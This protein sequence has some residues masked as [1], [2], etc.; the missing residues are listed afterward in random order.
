M[1]RSCAGLSCPGIHVRATAL[2]A[3]PLPA[4]NAA[5]ACPPSKCPLLLLVVDTQACP[6]L[7]CTASSSFAASLS[8]SLQ[9]HWA[10]P[11]RGNISCMT[12]FASF[13]L[14]YPRCSCP[15]TLL[16]SLSL[17]LTVYLSLYPSSYY[18][19]CP[20]LCTLSLFL[21]LCLSLFLG[22]FS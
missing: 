21:L 13:T 10:I 19:S 15:S 18:Y 12:S 11:G 2:C 7:S 22:I 1:S 14:N 4:P 6:L 9:L 5:R 16:L 20:S 3:L 17:Y 8:L